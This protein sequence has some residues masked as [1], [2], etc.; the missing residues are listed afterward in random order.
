MADR[1]LLK[2]EKS[3][4]L[5]SARKMTSGENPIISLEM[6]DEKNSTPQQMQSAVFQIPFADFE[7]LAR[8]SA[9]SKMKVTIE[10]L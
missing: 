1:Q 6:I 2:V 4:T 9:T 3:Y 10:V 7:T 5:V 8:P